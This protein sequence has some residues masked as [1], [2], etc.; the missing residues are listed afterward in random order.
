MKVQS[1]KSAH[2]LGV[3]ASYLVLAVTDMLHH[4]HAVLALG[5]ESALHAVVIGVVLVPIA[6]TMLWLFKKFGKKVI[7]A[8]FL[9]IAAVVVLLPGI[10]HG[11]WHYVV[12]LIAAFS[13]SGQ[14][15]SIGQLLPGDNLH[16]WFYEISG[17][18]EFFVA[19][20]CASFIIMYIRDKPKL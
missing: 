19:L 7:V 18:V 1:T 16:L 11:G 15:S 13:A 14:E 8:V 2:L 17:V 10:Y 9:L 20:V 4:L 12:K 5:Y 3:L 6:L